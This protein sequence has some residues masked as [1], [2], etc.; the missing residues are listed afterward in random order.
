MT[1]TS[2]QFTFNCY[3][4]PFFR[5]VSLSK[6]CKPDSSLEG[7]RLL[8]GEETCTRQYEIKYS[9][10]SG[11]N[12]RTFIKNISLLGITPAFSHIDK[13]VAKY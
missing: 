10:H 8:G 13:W 7:I 6:F 5:G 4:Q 3:K 9:V 11:M 1:R 2:C 12:K